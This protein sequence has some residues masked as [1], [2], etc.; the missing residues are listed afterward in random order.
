MKKQFLIILAMAA[1][2]LSA[3]AQ[4]TPAVNNQPAP[5]PVFSPASVE[6]TTLK[7]LVST[8]DSLKFCD[9]GNMDSQGYRATIIKE[10]SKVLSEKYGN[11]QDLI[12]ATIVQ[13]SQASS[14]TFVTDSEP[15]FLKIIGDTAYLKPIDGWAGVSIF[16]CGWQPLVEVNLLRFPEIKKVEWVNDPQKWQALK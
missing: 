2:S 10:V 1:L 12:V 7:F 13:A 3:C 5:T 8:E 15:D 6:T 16:L 9:G 11:R 14:M 4:T